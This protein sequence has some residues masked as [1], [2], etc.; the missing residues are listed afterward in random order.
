MALSPAMVFYSRMYIQESLFACFTLAFVIALGRVAT[1]GGL[2]WSALAGVAAGLAVATKE[3]SVIV[4]PAALVACAIAWWS[5]GS[6]AVARRRWPAGT[7]EVGR[8]RASTAARPSRR[9]STRRSS[10]IPP[11][12]SSRSAQ[13]APTSIAAS[14]PDTRP[15]VALLPRPARVLLV[16]GLTWSEALVLVLAAVGAV[17]R[18]GPPRAG[19]ASASE[20][21]LDALPHLQRCHRRGGLFGH[22]VQDAVEP[23]AVLRR[24]H[25]RGRNRLLGAR[26][27]RRRLARVAAR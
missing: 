17:T 25:R 13:P 26:R 4:L 18:L 2:G 23:A 9:S 1:G 15:P 16:G 20:G 14:T 6:P 22:P 12:S 8:L 19:D 11:A 21:V 24:R 10:P 27:T 5:L 7:G 3:T